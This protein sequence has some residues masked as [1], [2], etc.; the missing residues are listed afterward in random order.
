MGQFRVHSLG[1]S[2]HRFPLPNM[3]WEYDLKPTEFVILSYLCCFHSHRR[4]DEK[5]SAEAVAKAVH[6]TTGTVKK[7]LSR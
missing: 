5:T 6:M 3:V 4:N 2:L 1:Y 7:Y